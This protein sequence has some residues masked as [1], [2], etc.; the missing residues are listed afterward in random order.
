M[1]GV[2]VNTNKEKKWDKFVVVCIAGQSNA[3]GFDESLVDEN[4]AYRNL[5]SSRIKQLGFYGN[6]NLEIIDLG[7]CA[8]AMQDMRVHNRPNTPTSGTKGLH[9]PLANLMINHIPDDYGV[10]VLSISFGGTGFTGEAPMGT[11]SDILKKPI[12]MGAGEGTTAQ[13]WGV[14]TA[15]YETLRDR[16][17]YAL[18]L[19]DENKFAGI[20]WCQGENDKL[21]AVMHKSCFEA[22]TS[23][24][25]EELNET[26][27]GTRTPK[28]IWDKDIWYNM[29]TVSYWY[30]EGQCQKI[31]DN[32]KEWNEK[33]YIEIPRDTE[34]N[35]INGTGQTAAI[36]GAHYGNDAFEKVVA[37]RVL[38]KM[39]DMNTFKRVSQKSMT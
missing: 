32:Y 20:V 17:I 30:E 13:R 26:D 29:E 19:N 35:E 1:D 7:Y 21:D 38:Q 8:Q 15:Y 37:P 22:M 28:G 5:D 10:L 24:L 34:S 33:T 25:F 11:Y 27:L 39:I 3:V 31:W 12:E 9:L 16:I 36:R 14:D 4:I 2:C 6:D 23:K 18:K